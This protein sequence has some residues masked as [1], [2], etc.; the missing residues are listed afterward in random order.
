M[1]RDGKGTLTAA[2]IHAPGAL[3]FQA[4]SVDVDSH[5]PECLGS[6]EFLNDMHGGDV[7]AAALTRE[8]HRDWTDGWCL[9]GATGR[10]A[11][12]DKGDES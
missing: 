10:G 5:T 4:P 7:G 9:A 6:E 8:V 2:R 1:Q 3:A 11:Q 12:P